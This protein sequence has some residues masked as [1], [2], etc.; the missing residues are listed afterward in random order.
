MADEDLF[1]ELPEQK[2]SRPEDRGAPRLRVPE[3]SRSTRIG[4]RSTI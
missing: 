2:R 1:E 4:L 3:R